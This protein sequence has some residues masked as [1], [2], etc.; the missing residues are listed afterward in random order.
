MN[1]SNGMKILRMEC[2]FSSQMNISNCVKSME[3]RSYYILKND[4]LTRSAVKSMPDDQTLGL[5]LYEKIL[6]DHMNGIFSELIF[7]L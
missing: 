5:L 3:P 2:I 1:I 7:D 4:Y 6:F